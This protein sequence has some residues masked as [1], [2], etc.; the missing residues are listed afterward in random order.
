MQAWSSNSLDND[1]I[2]SLQPQMRNWCSWTFWKGENKIFNFHVG[3]NFIWS[4]L[5][6]VI[7]RRKPFHFWQF[8]ITSHF[9]FL[10]SFVLTLFSSMLM[11]EMS[12]ETC[13][14]MNEV[15]LTTS[16]LQ[17]QQLTCGWLLLTDRWLGHAQMNL[18]LNL[19]MKWLQNETLAYTSSI[20]SYDDPPSQWKPHL[21]DKTL[22]GTIQLIRVDQR[23]KS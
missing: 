11:F 23:S 3:Q 22:I 20:K 12:N 13:L 1:L 16:H 18:S 6:D 19:L 4:F 10:E 21:L 9:L 17:I 15:F 5:D 2:I 7:L 8:W 14:N